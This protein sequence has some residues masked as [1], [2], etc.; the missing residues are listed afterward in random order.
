ML[1]KFNRCSNVAIIKNMWRTKAGHWHASRVVLLLVVVSFGHPVLA[2]AL[3]S[4]LISGERRNLNVDCC[5]DNSMPPI[6]T[7][8]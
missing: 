2:F 1:L 5:M 7:M 3:V 4:G 6:V 8:T